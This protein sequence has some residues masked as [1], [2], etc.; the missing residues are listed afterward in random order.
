[1]L[2]SDKK[3]P[4]RVHVVRQ[5]DAAMEGIIALA[6]QNWNQLGFVPAEALRKA[7]GENTIIAATDGDGNVLGYA[8]YS[9][10]RS[11]SEARIHHLCVAQRCRGS[12]VGRRLV[13]EVK[14]RTKSF[15]AIVLR[16]R[17]DFE[18]SCKFWRQVGFVPFTEITGR[19]Q[20]GRVLTC[21]RFD[22]GHPDLWTEHHSRLA[23][24]KAVVVLDPNVF[25]DLADESSP[26]HKES[27]ALQADWISEYA[28]LW[29]TDEL[30]SEIDRN[31][32]AGVRSHSRGFAR[33]FPSCRADEAERDLARDALDQILPPAVSESDG[34]DRTHLATATAGN[35]EFFIT[36]DRV[37]LEHAPQIAERFQMN[38]VTPLEFILSIDQSQRTW[39]YQPARLAGSSLT[40][41]PISAAD[42]GRLSGEFLNHGGGERKADFE[43]RLCLALGAVRQTHGYVVRDADRGRGLLVLSGE[44]GHPREIVFLRISQSA[45]GPTLACH[46]A[47]RAIQIAVGEDA[48]AVIL[49]DAH[50]P[51]FVRAACDELGFLPAGE[52][53][54]KINL[55]GFY[56]LDAAVQ[57]LAEVGSRH[58]GLR[59]PLDSL[60]NAMNATRSLGSPPA[61][62]SRIEQLLWPMKLEDDS[63]TAF[64][65]P[66][67]AEWAKHLFEERLAGQHLFAADTSLSLQ[68]ENVY[69]RSAKP[70]IVTAPAH[71]LWYIAENSSYDGTAHLRACSRIEEVVIGPAKALFKRFSRLGIFAWRDVLEAAGQNPD[72]NLMAF[73]FAGTELLS[74]PVSM[75]EVRRVWMEERG[76]T[77]QFTTALQLSR[78]EFARLYT[79]GNGVL[80]ED[81]R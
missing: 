52:R 67:G 53:L 68:Y 59:E 66:I 28:G 75:H 48:P 78:R 69:Y 23:E 10:T 21:F 24:A 18:D 73:R 11:V 60:I 19:G 33:A 5:R 54:T 37:L 47:F 65:V 74:R 44:P 62:L 71:V 26:S 72:G 81:G 1:M 58:A 39:H 20:E 7:A 46:L 43:K 42:A 50:C 70:R 41:Q 3:L 13:D 40:I 36:R 34:S 15:R 12:G 6:D 29:I 63:L 79:I 4:T 35:A 14:D 80:A 76:V 22:H 61:E 25:F 16:C 2:S 32:D 31:G 38:V 9:V 51:D 49:A 45:L 27:L 77:P 8:W 64:M 57:K 55:K 56:T 17:R 30:Y